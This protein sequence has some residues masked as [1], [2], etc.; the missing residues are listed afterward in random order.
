[1]VSKI[2]INSEETVICPKCSA[3]F[4]IAQ[5]ITKQTIEEHEKAYEAVI[6]ERTK[7]LRDELS[8]EATKRAEKAYN[9]EIKDL[10]EL[11]RSAKEELEES[12][13]RI[14]KAQT[15]MKE[16]TLKDFE[17][18]REALNKELGEKRSTIKEFKEKELALRKEKRELEEQK[19]NIE[20]EHQRRLD[21]AKKDI[22]KNIKEAESE[23]FK[24]KEA[25]YKKQFADVSRVNEELTRKL[26]QGS[27][28]L[29]GEVLEL[30]LAKILKETFPHDNT[31]E[32]AKGARGADILQCVCT[33]TGQMCGSIIWETKRTQNWS[34]KWIDKLKDDRQAQKADIAVIVSRAMPKECRE[35]F[36]MIEDVWVVST[37]VV[38]P[39]AEALR[40]ML[41]EANKLKLA[42]LGKNEKAELVYNYLCSSNFARNIRSIIE[43][44]TNMK[45]D[46]DR[47]KNAMY[48]TW[49]KREIQLERVAV[50]MSTMVGELQEI[51]QNSIS[52][53]DAID[54]FLL[55]GES[56]EE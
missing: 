36:Q 47:E 18:E 21:E 32:V 40:I 24:F 46:L 10:K 39:V 44:F 9:S 55:P 34:N 52:Q 17:I 54:Q 5:G 19:E 51:S 15:E 29:Q 42:N 45:G 37:S 7:E 26:E 12:E 6:Q 53:L 49:K 31:K 38:R 2:I 41:I 27:Q 56:T 8:K 48:K 11:L 16:K 25:E 13:K 22:E 35:S 3:N 20:L 28:Q 1:M 4:P 50:G 43:T 30:E 33:S 23:K 14:K